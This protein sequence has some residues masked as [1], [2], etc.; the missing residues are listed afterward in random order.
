MVKGSTAGQHV[1]LEAERKCSTK[2]THLM[3]HIVNDTKF[4]QITTMGWP[5]GKKPQQHHTDFSIMCWR[6]GGLDLCTAVCQCAKSDFRK[7]FWCFSQC[8]H[9]CLFIELLRTIILISEQMLVSSSYCCFRSSYYISLH[10]WC[11]LCSCQFSP[12]LDDL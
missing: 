5:P 10:S 9:I 6:I 1:C 2:T 3:E 12:D 7:I 4:S 11:I 8:K